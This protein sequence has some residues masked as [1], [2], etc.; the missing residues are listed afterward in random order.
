ME[1]KAKKKKT[2]KNQNIRICTLGIFVYP[3]I[4]FSGNF[5][6]IVGLL[7]CFKMTSPLAQ[8]CCL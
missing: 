1:K 6:L 2:N 7:F 8:Q 5:L 3:D 4:S